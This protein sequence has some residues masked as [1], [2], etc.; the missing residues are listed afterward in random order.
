MDL[1]DFLPRFNPGARIEAVP[2]D[3]EHL[4]GKLMS[5][6]NVLSMSVDSV[7]AAPFPF[8]IEP[9]ALEAVAPIST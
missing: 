4:P 9:T 8:G 7:S 5:R 1:H 2:L 3:P 6:D